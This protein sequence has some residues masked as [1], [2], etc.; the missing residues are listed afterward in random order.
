MGRSGV[1]KKS[2]SRCTITE[3]ANIEVLWDTSAGCAVTIGPP[4]GG[5]RGRGMHGQQSRCAQSY[6][7]CNYAHQLEQFAA[8]Q[9]FSTLLTGIV[10][11][12][13]NLPA[14]SAVLPGK[15]EKTLRTGDTPCIPFLNSHL[16]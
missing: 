6:P 11:C 5:S 8:V 15:F 12:P 1:E 10:D 16:Q 3:P 9:S 2:A 7:G 13:F 4:V 14:G